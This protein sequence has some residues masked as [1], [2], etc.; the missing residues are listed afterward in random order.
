M[1]VQEEKQRREAFDW[2]WLNRHQHED[3]A[4]SLKLFSPLRSDEPKV[5]SDFPP[6]DLG[7][8]YHFRRDH[9]RV[10]RYLSQN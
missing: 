2:L 8:I 6:Q 1:E 7:I 10:S 4:I 9:L 5:G 3:G